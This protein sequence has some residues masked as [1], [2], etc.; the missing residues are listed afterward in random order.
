GAPARAVELRGVALLP[1]RPR[2]AVQPRAALSPAQR[3]P[4]QHQARGVR[5]AL[6]KD[7]GAVPGRPEHRG[8]DVRVGRHP[9]LPPRDVRAVGDDS[10]ARNLRGPG[11]RTPRAPLAA[12]SRW[13]ALRPPP[14][15]GMNIVHLARNA[16][17]PSVN[18]TIQQWIA[19]PSG[20]G[21]QAR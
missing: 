10:L 7:D 3:G 9:A 4:R 16:S 17:L 14:A 12:R 1:S 13:W 11:T 2:G 6:G 5:R 21:P 18:R 15:A 8:G 20:R 19:G